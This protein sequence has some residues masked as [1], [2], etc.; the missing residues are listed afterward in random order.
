MQHEQPELEWIAAKLEVSPSKLQRTFK[1]WVG[2]SPKKFLQHLTLDYAKARLEEGT[3][4]L[5]HPWLLDLRDHP[6]CMIFSSY[7]KDSPLVITNSADQVQQSVG[8]GPKALLVR[9]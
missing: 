6:A 5:T 3:S 9:R 2:L 7:T 8:A 4:V 1:R